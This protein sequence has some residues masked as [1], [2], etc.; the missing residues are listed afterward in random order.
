MFLLG[1]NWHR[2]GLWERL[3]LPRHQP[4]AAHLAPQSP[5]AAA[6]LCRTVPIPLRPMH[7][8]CPTPRLCS[9]P[10]GAQQE[11]PTPAA[12]SSSLGC[13]VRARQGLCRVGPQFGFVWKI[14]GGKKDA[15]RSG[16]HPCPQPAGLRGRPHEEYR[17]ARA[18]DRGPAAGAGLRLGPGCRLSPGHP[19]L[20]WQRH[21][22]PALLTWPKAA[23]R[24]G[25]GPRHPSACSA[26]ADSPAAMHRH[27]QACKGQCQR[28]L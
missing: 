9:Q 11:R 13:G 8:R 18:G 19:P 1:R 17:A 10:R 12:W 20:V 7:P 3:S 15:Q 27:C 24:A 26:C 22:H 25:T 2:K 14:T 4:S 6:R 16:L 23:A 5:P 21:P 28:C